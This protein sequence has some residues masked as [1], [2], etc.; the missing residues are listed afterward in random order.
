METML[1]GGCA[2]WLEKNHKICT[3][4]GAK[5][6]FSYGVPYLEIEMSHYTHAQSSGLSYSRIK[7]RVNQLEDVFVHP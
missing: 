3:R 1:G 6:V 4:G 7:F 2:A 5:K